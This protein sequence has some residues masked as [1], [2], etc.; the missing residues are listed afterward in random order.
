M[1]YDIRHLSTYAYETP[2]SFARCVLRLLPSDRPEQRVLSRA[3]EVKPVPAASGA[4]RSFFGNDVVTVTIEAAHRELKVDARSRVE[5]TRD[6]GDL[7]RQASRPW[8]DV[9]ER[10]FA[11]ATLAPSSP[12]H[13]LYPSRLVPILGPLSAY[14]RVSFPPGRP[15][16]EAAT[17]L[18]QRIKADFA[19]DPKAT[20]VSTP[21]IEAFE[22]RR[23]V[24]QDFAHIMI[25][26]LRGLGLP[27]AYVSGYL[28][29]LPPPGKKRLEGADAT[30]AWVTAW[31]GEEFGWLGF[32]PTNAVLVEND[33]IVL[34]SGRDYAD[35]SPIDGVI[36]GA[37]SQALTVKVDVVPVT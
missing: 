8:E 20:V 16:L 12:A 15:I 33:H 7:L 22:A 26:C 3:I 5:V 9:R 11:A 34:A 25:A 36:L 17:E 4:R 2:V 1:I 30:H 10:A 31:C 32:D 35:V 24:C 19:Y 14:A 23:G 28:R 27:A 29:T 6:T 21:L 13:Y 18:M 37:G